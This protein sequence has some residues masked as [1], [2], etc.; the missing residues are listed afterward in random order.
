MAGD[1][2]GLCRRVRSRCMRMASTTSCS[3]MRAITFI[4]EPQDGHVSGST[5][6][7]RIRSISSAQLRRG[8][9]TSTQGGWKCDEVRS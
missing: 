9:R 2:R 3:V 7:I 6:W 4:S 5:S 1:P 8:A